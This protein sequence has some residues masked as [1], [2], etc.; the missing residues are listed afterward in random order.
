[1]AQ[2]NRYSASTL[3]KVKA[4]D[5]TATSRKRNHRISSESAQKPE[6]A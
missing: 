1:M 4:V 2:P 3:P 6:S 5:R